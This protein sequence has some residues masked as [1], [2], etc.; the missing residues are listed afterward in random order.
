MPPQE[1]PALA[2]AC[3]H[4]L[5]IVPLYILD[6]NRLKKENNRYKWWLYRS[7]SALDTELKKR[8]SSLVIRKGSPAKVFKELFKEVTPCHLSWCTPLSPALQLENRKIEASLSALPISI[9]IFNDRL[10]NEEI[11]SFDQF[12]KRVKKST[13]SLLNPLP[14]SL[15]TAVL[16]SEKLETLYF[17]H[18][19]AYFS[20]PLLWKPGEKFALEHLFKVMSSPWISSS[21]EEIENE[22][23]RLFTR[24]RFGELSP[25]TIYRELELVKDLFSHD[26]ISTKIDLFI[27]ELLKREFAYQ[28]SPCSLSLSATRSSS[29]NFEKW[30]AGKTGYPI[31]DAAMRQLLLEGWLS[32]FYRK[33]LI[34]FLYRQFPTQINRGKKWLMLHL[35]D[36]HP[37]LLA[38]N[39]L[40]QTDFVTLSKKYDP[41]GYYIKRFIPELAAL[42][43]AYIHTPWKA[44][45]IE[46][47]KA[48]LFDAYTLAPAH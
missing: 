43:N 27:H 1:H 17:D 11:T 9:K 38:F 39:D 36:N 2:E 8:G 10:L 12:I 5:P 16:H 37:S 19:G 45:S 23:A 30:K 6:E 42:P 44:S 18:E 4:S 41:Q 22:A 34:S 20:N 21:K 24:L 32:P 40:L 35:L 28:N 46:L 47:K 31:I 7:L 26:P 3:S 48:K 15:P 13:C 14:A 29:I 25:R 33:L